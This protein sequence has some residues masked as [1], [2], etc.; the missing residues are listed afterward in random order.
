MLP[1]RCD[2][3]NGIPRTTDA[4]GDGATSAAH[5]SS[6]GID[7]ARSP[8][9]RAADIVAFYLF[10]V[11]ESINLQAIPSLIGGQTV[12]ARLSPKPATPPYVQYE[13]PPLSF[14]GDI[15]GV[16]EID[17]FRTRIRLYDYGVISVALTH[18]FAGGWHEL[19]NLG[20]SL[21][22]ND[23][24][25]RRAEDLCRLVMDRLRQSF[26]SPRSALL[27]EDYLV[28]AVTELDMPMPADQLIA[29]HGDEIAGML[30]GER[31]PLS[32]QEQSRILQA[33]ISYLA[34]DLVVPTWNAAFV[35]DTPAGAQ[36]AIEILEFANSQLLEF[37]YYDQLLDNQLSGIYAR[38]QRPRWFDQW[39]GS[40]HSRAARQVHALFIEVSELTDHTENALKFVGDVYAARLFALVADRLG[41]DKWKANVEAKLK[42]LDDIYRFAVEQSSMARG[43]FLE[44]TIVAILIL[45]LIL[46][47]LGIMN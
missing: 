45:E 15:V 4:R 24:L 10:D 42:T 33:R 17:G 14:D 2:G 26:A 18:P 5:V 6:A 23:D 28:V 8:A 22:E 34:D 35:Y 21:I 41:L 27:S 29:L 40:A 20:Q 13:K 9:I 43:T 47:F 46:F 3:P 12:A 44:L 7:P 31:K 19:V 32:E 39:I 16:A 30:R 38:V 11:A 36:A 1:L 25:E 37:R